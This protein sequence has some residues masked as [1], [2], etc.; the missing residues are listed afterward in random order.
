MTGG[1]F[2]VPARAQ[3][4]ES[5]FGASRDART[6]DELSPWHGFI[7]GYSGNRLHIEPFNYPKTFIKGT[8]M[9]MKFNLSPQESDALWEHCMAY[10]HT[11]RPVMERFVKGMKRVIPGRADRDS[12]VDFIVRTAESIPLSLGEKQTPEDLFRRVWGGPS[13]ERTFTELSQLAITP[14]VHIGWERA[15]NSTSKLSRMFWVWC[16]G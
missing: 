11:Q 12:S 2:I 10:D 15:R 5:R 7:V 1:G 6:F 3:S 9:V 13:A 4:Q 16:V 8:V 14:G